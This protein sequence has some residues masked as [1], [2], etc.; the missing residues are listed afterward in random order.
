[1]ADENHEVSQRLIDDFALFK[2]FAT[3]WGYQRIPVTNIIDSVHFVQ[4]HNN[5]IIQA[6]DLIT[7]TF[8]KAHLLHMAKWEAF[9]ASGAGAGA[10]PTWRA[11]N[12]TPSERATIGLRDQ[13]GG[14]RVFRAKIWP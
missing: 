13:I 5:R 3:N 6:C 11:Q 14:I 12:T 10:W 1:M 7:Y 2:E 9:S 4:S 8:L